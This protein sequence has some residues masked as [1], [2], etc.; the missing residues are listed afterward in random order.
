VFLFEEMAKLGKNLRREFTLEIS[1][2][3]IY[4][5]SVRDLFGKTSASVELMTDPVTKK[6][7]IPGQVWLKI[8]QVKDFLQAIKK[9]SDS[10]VFGQ[11]G[12]NDHSSRSHHI[13]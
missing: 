13:F 7:T 4:C 9:S 1:S 6:P 11:N 5:D 10:R 2:L 3:E 12:F 8:T